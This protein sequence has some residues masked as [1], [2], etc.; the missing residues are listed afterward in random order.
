M[1]GTLQKWWT[2]FCKGG[3]T[4]AMN[5]DEK[6]YMYTLNVYWLIS[7]IAYSIFL[8][9]LLVWQ[10]NGFTVLV[11]SN[12]IMYLL[13][14]LARYLMLLGR[15]LTARHVLLLVINAGIFFYD[16]II[17][18]HGWVFI[19]YIPFLFV[20]ISLFSYRAKTVSLVVYVLL[21]VLLFLITHFYLPHWSIAG[22]WVAVNNP[23]FGVGN[24]LMA[25]LLVALFTA[26]IIKGNLRNLQLIER[27]QLNLQALIDNTTDSV[28]SID[29]KNI[30][31]SANMVFKKGIK[32]MFGVDI[33]PGFDMN[34]IYERPD[35]PALFK[36]HHAL[37]FE[38]DSLHD[39]YRFYGNRHYEVFGTTYYD[40][41]GQLSGASFHVRDITDIIHSG[42]ELQ[43]AFINL[44]TLIDNTYASIWSVDTS[45]KVIAANRNYKEDMRRIFN[46]DVHPGYDISQIFD[47]PNYPRDWLEHYKRVFSGESYQLEY[48]FE[49]TVF[50]LMVAPIFGLYK[51]IIGAA[52]YARNISQRKHNELALLEAKEKAEEAA[53]AKAQFLS[54]ISHELRTPLNGIVA[55]TRIMLGEPTT[56][57]QYK[58]LEVLK[59]SGDHM[60]SLID[61]V[62]DFNKIEAG[63]VIIEKASFNLYQ[64]MEGLAKTFVAQAAE[65]GIGYEVVLPAELNRLVTGDVT[66]VTQVI[67]NLLGNAF[68]FT[69]K[70]KVMFSAALQKRG[71]DYLQVVFTV[72]DTGIGIAADKID[73]IF[74]SFTQAD[75]KTTRKYGGTGLGLTI[76]KRLVQLM[77]GELLVQ[78][79][80]GIG[81]TFTIELGF[82]LSQQLSGV[83]QEKGINELKKFTGV[84]VLLAEDN[85]INLMVASNILKKWEMEVTPV[86]DGREALDAMQ[87]ATFDLVLMDLEMPVLDGAAA[88]KEIRLTNQQVP[89]IAFTAASYENMHQDLLQKGMT[90]FVPKPFKPEHLHQCIS[91]ALQQ[92]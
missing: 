10:N 55:I 37:L 59:Y 51:S 28:W 21:P 26:N 77:D 79:E 71:P 75:V 36:K 19:Y 8:I 76:S 74:E 43:Q 73:K 89:I 14:L 68:K 91:D 9:L 12:L 67:N 18:F 23:L 57:E 15:Y 13:F 27:N 65:K 32:D 48:K 53:K 33:Q 56:P 78:S 41:Q 54:N 25:L 88:A 70:G 49:D 22:S 31:T 6:R 84:K 38:T 58:N 7:I 3:F 46:I 42:E 69:P 39:I 72:K 60:L 4:P 81:T 86:K 24:F 50:E 30:I 61:D 85:P 34:T 83:P 87:T 20:T 80:P 64:A 11:T 82:G 47:R 63:K 35:Y 17:G 5:N 44:Q 62:L 52:F 66:R 1:I 92:A 90:G 45:Y 16:G 2:K 40:K 29:S